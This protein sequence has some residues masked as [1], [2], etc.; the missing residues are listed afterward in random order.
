MA[1]DSDGDTTANTSEPTIAA[2]TNPCVPNIFARNCD[3][4]TDEDGI[5][6]SVEGNNSDTDS[7]GMPDY[8]ESLVTDSDGDFI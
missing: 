8:M 3:L 1:S 5:V 6:D 7:D 4:D 2:R